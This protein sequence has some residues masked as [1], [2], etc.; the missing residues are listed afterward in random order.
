LPPIVLYDANL[1]YPFHLRNLLVQLGV[2]HIVAPR[3]TAAIHDDWIGSLVAAGRA[4]RERLLRTRNIMEQ[5]LPE[6]NISGYEH[7]I[8]GLTLP[9]PRDRHVLAAAIHT[10]AETILTFNLKDFPTAALA[11]FGLIATDPDAFLC[12]LHIADPEAIVATVD[13]ARMNLSQTAPTAAAFIDALERQRLVRF[14]SQL[15]SA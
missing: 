11:P 14:A 6:A 1:L 5:V 9:D 12:D 2:H 3:W 7:R 10:H 13:A 4:P 15:R 8:A